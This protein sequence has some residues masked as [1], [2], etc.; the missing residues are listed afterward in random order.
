MTF[1]LAADP[2]GDFLKQNPWVIGVIA[3]AFFVILWYVILNVVG[4]TSGWSSLAEHYRTSELFQGETWRFQSARMRYL[5]NYNG[6]LTFGAG[7]QGMFAAGWGPF[8]I[9]AP[10]LLVPWGELTIRPK[11]LWLMP[12]YELRFQQSPD[13]F[14]WVRESLGEN[15]LRFSGK[16]VSGIRMAQPIG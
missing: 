9:G 6:C 7:M 14:M 1:A 3:P 16:D 8:R 10:P 12:G 5:S 15:L 2:V 4:R 13:V 11:K